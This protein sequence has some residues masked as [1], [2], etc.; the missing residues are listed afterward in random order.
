MK[1][2]FI[3]SI[4][5][6]LFC[7]AVSAQ[8]ITYGSGYSGPLA[9]DGEGTGAFYTGEYRDLFVDVLGKSEAQVQAKIDKVWKHF[10]TPGASTAVYCEVGDDMA[11]IHDVGNNDVR[12]E[13]QSYGMMI[14][15]QLDHK[16]EFDKLWR[17]AKK[18]MQHKDGDWEGYFAWQC[19][20]DGTIIDKTCAPDGEEYFITAL[21]LAANRWGSDGEID[22][23]AEAQN[24][25]TKI[26]SKTGKNSIHNMFN[27]ENKLV[28]FAPNFDNVTFSDPSYCLPGFLEL[29]ARWADKNNDFWFAAA[30]SARLLLKNSCNSTSG[31]FPDYSLFDG[32]PYRP[33]WQGYDTKQYKFDAIRCAMNVGM[34]Y[35]WFRSDSANQA[36]MMTRL[37]TFFKSDNYQHGYFDWD[38][39]NPEG[40]YNEGVAG[41]NGVACFAVNDEELT[42]K[43]LNKLWN[44][45]PPTG[46]WRYYNGMVYF[47]SLLNVTGN[48][49]IYKPVSEMIDTTVYDSF[50]GI[51][52]DKS[53]T[54]STAI[55]GKIY[56]VNVIVEKTD[57]KTTK[58]CGLIL[59]PNP[60]NE[61]FYINSDKEIASVELRNV[62]GTLISQTKQTRDVLVSG[63][64]KGMYLVTVNFF[65]NSLQTLKLEIN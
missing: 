19:K 46:Q 38:G 53:T 6:G 1:K 17:W 2:H 22:Y 56:H 4:L 15:V 27:A 57:I 39:G 36:E 45:T 10:F 51:K 35:N 29:W 18:Y 26:M 12:T 28:V 65:D 34:D 42:K 41:T 50:N 49:R 13:G 8:S 55:N 43:V 62:E 14:S 11:Y 44:T 32:T 20:T 24:I 33:D 40:T 61:K 59:Y 3:L 54:F 5:S 21:F 7:I 31:L 30:D 25:L 47:L 52:F 16:T 9:D 48:Y 60:A 23:N 63:L 58:D 37:L 64:P